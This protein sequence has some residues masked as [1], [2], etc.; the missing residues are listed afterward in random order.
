MDSPPPYR[1]RNPR[2]LFLLNLK[3]LSPFTISRAFAFPCQE[4]KKPDLMSLRRSPTYMGLVT[5]T[6]IDFS[7]IGSPR[8]TRRHMWRMEEIREDKDLV[9]VD[10]YIVVNNKQKKRRHSGRSKKEKS[11]SFCFIPSPMEPVSVQMVYLPMPEELVQWQVE[12]K[13][14]LNFKVVN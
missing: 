10:E 14:V 9:V 8:N 6:T 13:H 12:L 5:A 7:N 2:T 3:P 1:P 11:I 4:I